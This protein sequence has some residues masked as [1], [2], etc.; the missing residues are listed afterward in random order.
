MRKSAKLSATTTALALV[1]SKVGDLLFSHGHRRAY[2]ANPK[3][4]R[5]KR[6]GLVKR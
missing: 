6:S 1:A 4:I 2:D 5:A 3:E